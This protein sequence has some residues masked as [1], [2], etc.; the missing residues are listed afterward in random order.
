MADKL[1]S[2][3][4]ARHEQSETVQDKDGKW[5]NVYG[6]QTPQAGRTLPGEPRYDSVD[7]AVTGAKARSAREGNYAD[8]DA[9][10]KAYV[11]KF[12]AQY[13]DA[14]EEDVRWAVE[15]S[16]LQAPAKDQGG[17]MS[18]IQGAL[19]AARKGVQYIDTMGGLMPGSPAGSMVDPLTLVPKDLTSGAVQTVLGLVPGS[20]AA[21][22]PLKE[23]AGRLAAR[24]AAPIATG[25]VVGGLEGG[26][27]R[28]T[29]GAFEGV[30]GAG[31]GEATRLGG[32]ALDFIINKLRTR[33][34]A[35]AARAASETVAPNLEAAITADVPVLKGVMTGDPATRLLFLRDPARGRAALASQFQAADDSVIAHF[36]P[37]RIELASLGPSPQAQKT[38]TALGMDVDDPRLVRILQAN[39]I[40]RYRE[41]AAD[42]ALAEIKNMKARARDAYTPD[43]PGA[44]YDLRQQAR[45]LEAE[46]VELLPQKLQASY[47][48]AIDQYDR[49]LDALDLL[50]RFGQ[51]GGFGGDPK[52]PVLDVD[53]LREF[54]VK[55]I[56]DFPPSRFESVW[57]GQGGAFAG[58]PGAR[59]LITK[60][61]G[62]RVFLPQ[63]G[64]IPGGSVPLPPTQYR[65]RV[66]GPAKRQGEYDMPARLFS[67]ESIRQQ[68]KR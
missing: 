24:V 31:I 57:F 62:S 27:E 61:F 68:D 58:V 34:T 30:L 45:F 43:N 49:G 33:D 67:V 47:R 12:K 21:G 53:K 44:S 37:R 17:P 54:L 2:F 64:P 40:P 55:N 29:S 11:I 6:S 48:K 46:V 10:D 13:P 60:M 7:A 3:T 14:P 5:V 39:K 20:A 9:A 8:L 19:D 42:E 51:S 32:R 35:K 66:G 25:G 22:A 38:A 18:V 36:G 56:E 52:G 50:K 23:G 26:Q 41:M 63:L 4:A 28:A 59:D 65:D 16:K 1:H 15:Q